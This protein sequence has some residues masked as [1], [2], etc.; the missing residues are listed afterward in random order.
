M[1]G[2]GRC[3]YY[4]CDTCLKTPMPGDEVIKLRRDECDC[5]NDLY[6]EFCSQECL[7]AYEIDC[8]CGSANEVTT[9]RGE[10]EK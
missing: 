10:S 7:D 6:R 2:N 9:T 4:G 3:M 8:D 1:C 5:T